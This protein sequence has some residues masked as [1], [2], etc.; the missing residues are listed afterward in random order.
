[1]RT[2]CLSLALAS[3]SPALAAPS[4][5]PSQESP[6]ERADASEELV[7][8]VR[9]LRQEMRSLGDEVRG[10]SEDVRELER[11][12]GHSDERT[13]GPTPA[14]PAPAQD[15]TLQA[16]QVAEQAEDAAEQ[17]AER[18]EDAAEQAAEQAE[19][20]AE[21]VARLVAADVD[22]RNMARKLRDKASGDR[23]AMVGDIRIAQGEVVVDVFT[24]SGDIEVAGTVTG[25]AVSL[26]GN[27]TVLDG[28][29]VLGDASSMRGDVLVQP[30]GT[31]AGEAHT[32]NGAVEVQPGGQVLGSTMSMTMH[33]PPEAHGVGSWISGV[34][35]WFYRRLVFFLAF[36]GAGVLVIALFQD[37]VSSVARALEDKPAK[38][39]L[40]G[41]GWTIGLFVA[42]VATFF[43]ILGPLA[44]FAVLGLAWL[45]GFV[46]L[47]QMLGDRLG[48]PLPYKHHGRW[49][50]FLVGS[51]LVT[52]IGSLPFVGWIVIIAASLFGMGAA[53]QTRFGS[54]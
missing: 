8:L 26:N 15:A 24:M 5:A 41:L 9:E 54:R 29:K 33:H 18:A 2:L 52:F 25:D 32:L 10:L 31:L 20:E 27:V 40:L 12:A 50:A 38:A 21:D 22:A 42:A 53:F 37:R 28:G 4:D 36:A 13:R 47:C 51:L 30:G 45:L 34:A 43:T 3:A 17:A 44:A 46:G 48:L 1:M 11:K 6:S 14:P 39:G 23:V 35:G 16:E 7:D 49:L 19:A